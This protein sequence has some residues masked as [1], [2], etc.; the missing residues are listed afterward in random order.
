[1][2][3]SGLLK[4]FSKENILNGASNTTMG[5]FINDPPSVTAC[6]ELVVDFFNRSDTGTLSR[7]IEPIRCGLMMTS[8]DV[9]SGSPR[10]VIRFP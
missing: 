9:L 3:K 5:V 7:G 4:T 1:M 8:N 10:S 2:L 6:K